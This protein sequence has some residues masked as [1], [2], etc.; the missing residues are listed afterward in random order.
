[1]CIY[2]YTHIFICLYLGVKPLCVH[3]HALSRSRAFPSP[4]CIM[5]RIIQ[6]SGKDKGGPT[7]GGFLNNRLGS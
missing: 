2:I 1:M 3:G 4:T 6:I 5:I 7:K